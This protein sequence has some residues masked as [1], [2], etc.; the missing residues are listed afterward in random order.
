MR[1]RRIQDGYSDAPYFQRYVSNRALKIQ[2]IHIRG[3]GKYTLKVATVCTFQK[4]R[5]KGRENTGM[6]I[7]TAGKLYDTNY[8]VLLA[9][10]CNEIYVSEVDN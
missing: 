2:L 10:K 1:K 4:C 3:I 9:T 8:N 7:F 6:E 5:G